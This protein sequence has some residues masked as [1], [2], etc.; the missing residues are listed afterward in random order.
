[1][2]VDGSASSLPES[3]WAEGLLMLKAVIEDFLTLG[4][5]VRTTLDAR[6]DAFQLSHSHLEITRVSSASHEAQLFHE[7]TA[8]A[9]AAI[10]IA[11]E[12]HHLLR[13]RVRVVEAFGTAVHLG[14]SS[15]AIE[16]CG[17]KLELA[18]LLTARGIPTIP[19][20]PF[21]ATRPELAFPFPVVVKPRHGAGS[22]LTFRLD[23]SSQLRQACEEI[24]ASGEE[25]EFIQQPFIN[26]RSLA[27]STI[28]NQPLPLSEQ[29]L[30][31][32]GRFHYLGTNL[33][34]QQA[35]SYLAVASRALLRDCETAID[36]LNG[37]VGFDLIEPTEAPGKPLLVEINPRFTSSY[38]AYR[39]ACETNLAAVLLS[40]DMPLIWRADEIRFRV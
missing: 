34:P 31:D 19:T 38:L 17:D 28:R 18:R 12:F 10:V 7:L 2:Q 4:W 16:L 40:D 35:D 39:A 3:L 23:D 36:G 33:L 20:Q 8:L 6:V 1:M 22:T 14:C 13:D 9:T 32:D 24:R 15:R 37:Y 30:S 25:F 11:P 21:D 26:G 27:M 5:R 29:V